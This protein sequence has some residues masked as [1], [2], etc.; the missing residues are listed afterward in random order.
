MKFKVM[1]T[2]FT[3]NLKLREEDLAREVYDSL[4]HSSLEG[5]TGFVEVEKIDE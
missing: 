4:N 5:Y 3:D 2:V 1:F